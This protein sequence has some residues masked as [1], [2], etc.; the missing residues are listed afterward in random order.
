MENLNEKLNFGEVQILLYDISP[1]QL[2][3]IFEQYQLIGEKKGR[4]TYYDA[5]KIAFMY[6]QKR[7]FKHVHF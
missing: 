5:Q 1:L 7:S 3:R 4:Y 2:R 6:V